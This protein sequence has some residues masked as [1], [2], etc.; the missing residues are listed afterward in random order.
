MLDTHLT[1]LT[2]SED[3][4]RTIKE[5]ACVM[6]CCGRMGPMCIP[7]YRA[8]ERLESRYP[9]VSFRDVDFDS[10]AATG[11]KNLKEC[12]SF[13]SL[14]FTVYYFQGKLVSAASGL[15]S[16]EDITTGLGRYFQ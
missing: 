10:P 14:P 13:M 1:H 11:I 12:A 7:V 16:E 5:N 4:A 6:I 2:S 9:Q 8:M 3:V 15:Q